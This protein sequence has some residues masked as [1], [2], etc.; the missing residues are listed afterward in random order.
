MTSHDLCERK[1]IF[2]R[3]AVALVLVV[4]PV[5]DGRWQRLTLFP[6]SRGNRGVHMSTGEGAGG[7]A[8]SEI[9]V[10]FAHVTVWGLLPVL[11]NQQASPTCRPTLSLEG[12]DG[13]RVPGGILLG[14]AWGVRMKKSMWQHPSL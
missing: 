7:T 9:T 10:I 12:A 11:F 4:L 3:N 13:K 5:S 2:K 6:H 14:T 1:V 8:G